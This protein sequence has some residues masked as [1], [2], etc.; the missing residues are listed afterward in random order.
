VRWGFFNAVFEQKEYAESYV[1]EP[2]IR[3]MLKSDPY[4]TTEFNEKMQNDK[5]FA[6]NPRA[7]HNWFYMR[8]K[9][10]DTEKDIVPVYRINEVTLRKIQS[11]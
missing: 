1:M 4:L 5:E 7:I 6:S 8:T 9:Y 3:S 2:L 10:R 11:K